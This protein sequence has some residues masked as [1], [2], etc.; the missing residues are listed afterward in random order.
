MLPKNLLYQTKSESA[1]ARSYKANI[2]PQNGTG[3]YTPNQTIIINIPTSPNLV[4]AMSENYLKF[5]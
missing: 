4:T 1:A 5:L 3:P 2:A